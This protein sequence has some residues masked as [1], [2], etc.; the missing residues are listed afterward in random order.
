[1]SNII[2]LWENR[3]CLLLWWYKYHWKF[4]HTWDYVQLSGTNLSLEG[5]EFKCYTNRL[6]LTFYSWL[7]TGTVQPKSESKSIF[8]YIISSLSAPLKILWQLNLVMKTLIDLSETRI[9]DLYPWMRR[10]ASRTSSYGSS[11]PYPLP[12]GKSQIWQHFKHTN[13]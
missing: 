4:A 9:L 8:L 5:K 7:R 10:L 12:H 1:M 13:I 2:T 3:V 11:R 6:L